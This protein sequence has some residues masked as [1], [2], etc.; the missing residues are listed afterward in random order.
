MK[1]VLYSPD[2][3]GLF[4]P[5]IAKAV[6]GAEVRMLQIASYLARF[7]KVV[8][9]FHSERR[10]KGFKYGFV[11]SSCGYY[12]SPSGGLLYRISN[13]FNYLFF[14]DK[15]VSYD[16]FLKFREVYLFKPDV[17]CSFGITSHT[18]ALFD[19]VINLRTL[20]VLFIA[21]DEEI[22]FNDEIKSTNYFKRDFNITKRIIQSADICFV[23]N[24]F[25]KNALKNFFNRVSTLILNPIEINV[26]VSI[27]FGK[28]VLWVGK[29]V[30]YKRPELFI[31]LANCMPNHSFVMICNKD[32]SWLSTMKKQ[33]PANLIFI[34]HI[35]FEKIE[36]YFKGCN[37]FVNTSL[38]E[39]FP[40]TFLQAMKFGKPVFSLAVNPNNFI[41]EYGCGFYAENDFSALLEKIQQVLQDRNMYDSMAISALNYIKL[42]DVNAVCEIVDNQ[43]KNYK[44]R[45]SLIE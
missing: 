37:L 25:Q 45:N 10:H 13:R 9:L 34:E 27:S 33:L 15:G 16:T 2:S 8:V 39:G 12:M 20:K 5:G 35:P 7:H 32:K 28:Y 26:D 31:K 6:G 41:N 29:D 14:V 3:E 11:F 40:N 17:V 1:I 43:I 42:H 36:D 24:V 22:N 23:Q 4:I 18:K 44:L 21:S 38:F 19:S 30:D